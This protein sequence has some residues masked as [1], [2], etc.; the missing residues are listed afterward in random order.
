MKGYNGNFNTGQDDERDPVPQCRAKFELANGE[1]VSR[2][3]LDLGH[4]EA[5]EGWCLVNGVDYRGTICCTC[6]ENESAH[7]RKAVES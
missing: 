2:C 6:G 3:H 1:F 5:H 4:K 7:G